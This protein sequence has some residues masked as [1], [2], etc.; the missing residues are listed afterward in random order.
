M[1]IHELRALHTWAGDRPSC[2]VSQ[3]LGSSRGSLN[4]RDVLL[5]GTRYTGFDRLTGL[6]ETWEI[7][8]Y[9]V[10]DGKD[11][12]TDPWCVRVA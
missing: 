1:T 5:V 7:V 2:R 8:P 12:R 6:P 10:L 9:S 4:L 3:L 11:H